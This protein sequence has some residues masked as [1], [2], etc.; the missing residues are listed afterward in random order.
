MILETIAIKFSEI[1]SFFVCSQYY[2]RYIK[3]FVTISILLNKTKIVEK[4]QPHSGNVKTMGIL[5]LLSLEFTFKINSKINAA[6][7]IKN[8]RRS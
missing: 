2:R 3:N 8:Q 4:V 7:H 1:W 5:W 6:N